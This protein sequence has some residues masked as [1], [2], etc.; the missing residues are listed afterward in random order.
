MFYGN[1]DNICLFI[2]AI[3]T[4]FIHCK[5]DPSWTLCKGGSKVFTP[6]FLHQM[7]T[8]QFVGVA[9]SCEG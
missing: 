5:V 7:L 1:V 4:I 2:L 3:G 8:V 6:F 9:Q